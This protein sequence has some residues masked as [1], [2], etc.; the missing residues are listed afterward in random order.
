MPGR[1]VKLPRRRPLAGDV[2]RSILAGRSEATAAEVL[3]HEGDI[4]C[5]RPRER[6]A[7]R[8]AL[9]G[10][11]HPEDMAALR[12]LWGTAHPPA[13]AGSRRQAVA[14]ASEA[15]AEDAYDAL[16]SAVRHALAS[17]NPRTRRRGAVEAVRCGLPCRGPGDDAGRQG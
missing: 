8:W 15:D 9:V 17:D 14:L 6:E 1:R 3:A 13:T 11:V 10:H 7:L 16:P 12:G 5:L 2:L 4:L